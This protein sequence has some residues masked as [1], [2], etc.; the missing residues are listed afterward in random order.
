MARL[1]L[2]GR[3]GWQ[4]FVAE[5]G[6]AG[7]ML[8]RCIIRDFGT[9]IHLSGGSEVAVINNTLV[10]NTNGLVA[11]SGN[12]IN[13]RNTIFAY[14]TGVGLQYDSPSSLSNTYNDFWS[15]G[16]DIVRVGGQADPSLGSLFVDPRFRS[17]ADD[18]L[19]LAEDSPL[20]DRGAPGDPTAPGGGER[21]DIGYAEASAASFYVSHR[22]SE[23]GINDGLTW[24]VDAFDTI[25]SAL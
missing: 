12:P 10:R 19:R 23:V 3:A 14:S 24:G 15:N 9:G 13:V 20:I 22:Y 21:V 11:D 5:G 8:T 2:A 1:T 25:Q 17:L 7:V 18:D 16:T 4:G 6:T